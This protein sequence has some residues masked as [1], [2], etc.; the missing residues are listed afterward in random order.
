VAPANDRT[1]AIDVAVMMDSSAPVAARRFSP[2]ERSLLLVSL[3]NNAGSGA[4]LTGSVVYFTRN[5][6]LPATGVAAA[7]S[8]AGLAGL[9]MTVPAGLVAERVGA[10]RTL[11]ILHILRTLGYSTF[12]LAGS[13]WQFAALTIVLTTLDQAANPA[14]QALVATVVPAGHR[15][16]VMSWQYAAANVGIG[17]GAAMTTVVLGLHSAAGF[18]LIVLF[19]GLSF[20]CSALLVAL[21]RAPSHSTVDGEP[22]PA[23]GGADRSV[24]R[25]SWPA[26]PYLLL[27]LAATAIL[28]YESVLNVAIPVWVSQRTVAPVA[29]VGVLAIVNTVLAALLQVRVSR[30]VRSVSAAGTAILRSSLVLAVGCGLF[31]LA[32]RWGA[33]VATALLVGAVVA[34]SFGEMLGG[35]GN[36][37]LSVEL[38]PAQRRERYLAVFGLSTSIQRVIGPVFVAAVLLGLGATGWLVTAAIFLAGGLLAYRVAGSYRRAIPAPSTTVPNEAAEAS[39]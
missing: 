14:A 38:A 9:V 19:N 28:L 24:L 29:V 37:Y 39:R 12:V 1:T 8:V 11:V 23:A 34:I 20:A 16:R 31:A 22:L 36:W 18:R 26:P 21:I 2:A 5:V 13:L 25:G 15:V 6:G 7:I 27:T 32:S 4:F 10:Q 35:S 33:V 3:V 30:A 17:I